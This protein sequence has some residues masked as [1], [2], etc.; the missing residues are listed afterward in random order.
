MEPIDSLNT[1]VLAIL[2][3]KSELRKV[4]NVNYAFAKFYGLYA[5]KS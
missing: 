3:K 2:G 5:Q 4:I 1:R